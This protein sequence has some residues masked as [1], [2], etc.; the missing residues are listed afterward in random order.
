MKSV[1][2]T[3]L[4][5]VLVVLGACGSGDT[6]TGVADPTSSELKGGSNP[7]GTSSST[8]SS[9]SNTSSDTDDDVVV[10]R[11]Q[12]YDG[13]LSYQAAGNEQTWDQAWTVRAACG[14]FSGF[15]STPAQAGYKVTGTYDEAG[16]VLTFVTTSALPANMDFTLT[17]PADSHCAYRADGSLGLVCPDDH[18]YVLTGQ[19]GVQL[20]LSNPSAWK[21]HGE[22]VSSVAKDPKSTSAQV[23]A[24]A[25]SCIGKPITSEDESSDDDGSCSRSLCW[26]KGK[27]SYTI[28]GSQFE[29]WTIT[30]GG[31]GR[32]FG[33]LSAS[34]PTLPGGAIAGTYDPATKTVLSFVTTQPEQGCVFIST[35][36]VALTCPSYPGYPA[37]TSG[38]SLTTGTSLDQP[39]VSGVNFTLDATSTC[40]KL[41]FCNGERPVCVSPQ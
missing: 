25:Q 30:A 6:K 36:P 29:E 20:T 14:T 24:A 17:T 39:G 41:P 8:T 12:Q 35:P 21:N 37:I 19:A 9:S 16:K 23:V 26:S 11:H 28:G 5:A 34:N 2:S 10:A 1:I 13:T 33:H 4:A 22:Y 31:D 18:A 27:L 40:V 3:G 7:S 38:K 15:L 32:F